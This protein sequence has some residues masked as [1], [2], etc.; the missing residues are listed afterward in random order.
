MTNMNNNRFETTYKDLKDCLSWLSDN[1]ANDL[2]ERELTYATMML[3]LCEDYA[4]CYED[5]L[6]DET[7]TRQDERD[8][9][10]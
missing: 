5:E 2:S 3:Q 9:L 10:K 6:L 1:G 4:R 7:E 8:T